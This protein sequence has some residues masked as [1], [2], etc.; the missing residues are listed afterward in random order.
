MLAP[1][2]RGVGA[3]SSGKYWI[4]YWKW[5]K[6]LNET[7]GPVLLEPQLPPP[8]HTHTTTFCP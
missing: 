7:H 4:R 1:P 2:L 8:P 3:P 5:L 6:L